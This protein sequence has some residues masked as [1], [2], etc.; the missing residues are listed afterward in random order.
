MST[1]PNTVTELWAPG[2]GSASGTI[3][4]IHRRSC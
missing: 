4:A 1:S 3:R 2:T